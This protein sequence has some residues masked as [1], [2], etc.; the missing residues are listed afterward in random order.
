MNYVNIHDFF[1]S[2]EY[3]GVQLSNLLSLLIGS[4]LKNVL[5]C[6]FICHNAA[7][8]KFCYESLFQ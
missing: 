8:H 7:N 4:M 1:K 3:I 2:L 6:I 5:Y